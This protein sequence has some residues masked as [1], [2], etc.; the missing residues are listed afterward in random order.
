MITM[1]T[2]TFYK[3]TL[4]RDQAGQGPQAEG[5]SADRH[6]LN[7]GCADG[8]ASLLTCAFHAGILLRDGQAGA[9]RDERH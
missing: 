9:P 5:P 8:L 7:I 1:A 3:I 4:A 2:Y 6:T